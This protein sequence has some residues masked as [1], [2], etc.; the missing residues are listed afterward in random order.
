MHGGTLERRGGSMDRRRKEAPRSVAA[1]GG[2]V[3]LAW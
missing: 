1:E 2:V 3:V